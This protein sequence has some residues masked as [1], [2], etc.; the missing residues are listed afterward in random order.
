M[1]THSDQLN[2]S[3]LKDLNDTADTIVVKLQ[4]GLL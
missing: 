2:Y 4:R 3:K 1:L